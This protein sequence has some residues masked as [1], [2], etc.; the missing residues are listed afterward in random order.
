MRIE[1]LERAKQDLREGIQFYERQAEGVGQYFLDSMT[2]DIESL[3][4]FAGVH[5]RQSGLYQMIA[6]RFPFAVYYRVEKEVV[7]I[8]AVLD[9][10]RDPAW[11][12]KRLARES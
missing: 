6:R 11:I 3:H 5:A 4:L 9:C 12:G 10:R 1:I 7:R 2:A 8:H